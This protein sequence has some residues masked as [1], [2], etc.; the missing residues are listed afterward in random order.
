M[1]V[2]E[3]FGD[4]PLNMVVRMCG[5]IVVHVVYSSS[6]AQTRPP[7]SIP[8]CNDCAL[9]LPLDSDVCQALTVSDGAAQLRWRAL[10]WLPGHLYGSMLLLCL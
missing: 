9:H 6:R 2:P 7:P 3:V 10:N 1:A 8:V 4:R 5:W